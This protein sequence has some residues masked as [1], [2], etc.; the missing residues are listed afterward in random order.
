MLDQIRTAKARSALEGK[1]PMGWAIGYPCT[2]RLESVASGAWQPAQVT[3]VT[4]DGQ[5]Q[6][7]WDGAGGAGMGGAA[8]VR[9]EDCRPRDRG[10]RA[11]ALQCCDHTHSAR[12]HAG[13]ERSKRMCDAHVA[14]AAASAECVLC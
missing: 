7:A 11:I 8:T 4:P 13:L 5:F 14:A 1:A 3:A 10:V 9:R 6:I 12:L 2:A